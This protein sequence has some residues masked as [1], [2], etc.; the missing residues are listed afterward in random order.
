MKEISLTSPEA[1]RAGAEETFCH[2]HEIDFGTPLRVSVKKE[3]STDGNMSS[4]SSY[5]SLSVRQRDYRQE[6]KTLDTLSPDECR[7]SCNKDVAIYLNPPTSNKIRNGRSFFDSV[8]RHFFPHR[9]MA[10]DIS[11][12]HFFGQ[13]IDFKPLDGGGTLSEVIDFHQALCAKIEK[14][15]PQLKQTEPDLPDGFGLSPTFANVFLVVDGDVKSKEPE[16]LVV[17]NDA[18]LAKRLKFADEEIERDAN[19]GS[20]G[21]MD[22]DAD[23]ARAA[24]PFRYRVGLIRSMHALFSLDEKRRVGVQPDSLFWKCQITDELEEGKDFRYVR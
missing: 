23:A 2:Y 14:E 1:K 10:L 6:R 21:K 18:E 3:E 8:Y 20:A 17:C 24:W 16:V 12:Y 22:R 4:T 7:Y 9:D 15:A 13:L 5:Y 11:G 19:A